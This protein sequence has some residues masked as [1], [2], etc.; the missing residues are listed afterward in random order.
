LKRLKHGG[1]SDILPLFCKKGTTPKISIAQKLEGGSVLHMTNAS[2]GRISL[3]YLAY[4]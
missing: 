3:T 4:S 1:K 2:K